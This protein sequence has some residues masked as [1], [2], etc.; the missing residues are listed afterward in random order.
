METRNRIAQILLWVSILGFTTWVGGTLYQMLVIVPMWSASPPESLRAFL[1]GT[2]FNE[3]IGHF[4]GPPIMIARNAPPL[5]ALI[6]GWRLPHRKWLLAAT[7]CMA[8]GV[9]FTVVY[10]Y[11][12]NAVLFTQA[13]DHSPE[14]IGSMLHRWIVADRVRFG[15][16]VIGFLS[17][18]RALSIPFPVNSERN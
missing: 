15:V 3:M 9:I 18:L 1:S 11:P 7:V 5:A 13:G 16:G 12:I 17:L 2:R 8:S 14:E 10:I 6:F 4:F